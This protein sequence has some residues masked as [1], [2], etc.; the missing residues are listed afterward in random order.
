M[1]ADAAQTFP[2]QVL[3]A[4][5]KKRFKRA[6]DRNRIKRITRE[7]YRLNKQANLYDQLDGIQ[8][9][10]IISLGYIGKELP[11]YHLAEKKMLKLL[12]QLCAEAAR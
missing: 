8:K 12:K 4:V 2:A 3:F 10:I 11:E 6:V 1:F 5:S 7:V 9:R